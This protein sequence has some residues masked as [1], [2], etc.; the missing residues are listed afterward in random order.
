MK[1]ALR[2]ADLR[3]NDDSITMR[4]ILCRYAN[5]TGGRPVESTGRVIVASEARCA[6]Q[7]S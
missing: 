1:N 6:S 5:P 2:S 3:A 7:A 4:S